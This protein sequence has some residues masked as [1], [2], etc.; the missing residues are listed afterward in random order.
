MSI[1]KIE[2]KIAKKRR[3]L[4][5]LESETALM[6]MPLVHETAEKIRDQIVD[7]QHLLLDAIDER[8]SAAERRLDAAGRNLDR[9]CAD[10][11]ARLARLETGEV[12]R[13]LRDACKN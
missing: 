10:F 13:A 8:T 11:S 12:L 4:R 9:A 1:T 5:Q 3:A 6:Q 7:L 2:Q